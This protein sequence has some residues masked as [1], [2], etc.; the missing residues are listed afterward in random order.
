VFYITGGELFLLI[1]APGKTG[2]FF[3]PGYF[4]LGKG[5]FATFKKSPGLNTNEKGGGIHR[6]LK[7]PGH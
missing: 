4:E 1:A 2:A 6:G 7:K 3:C 5:Y